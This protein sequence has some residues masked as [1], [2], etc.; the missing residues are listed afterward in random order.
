MKLTVRSSSWNVPNRR[1]KTGSRTFPGVPA[2]GRLRTNFELQTYL[3]SWQKTNA[4][5]AYGPLFQSA[6]GGAPAQFCGGTVASATDGGNMGFSAPHGL[7]PGRRS[8]P[9]TRSALWRRSWTQHR[10]AERAIYDVPRGRRGDEAAVTYSPATSLPTVSI[11]DYWTPGDGGAE[12]ALRRRG[13]SNGDFGQRRLSRVPIQRAGAGC[14]RQQQFLGRRLRRCRASRRNRRSGLSTT[15]SFREIW[16]K[17]GSGP[18][19]SQFFTVT[20]ASIGLKNNLE[21]RSREFG[22]SLPLAIAPGR[23]SVTAAF[24]LYSQET[25]RRAL[26]QAARQESPISVMFQLGN[27]SGQMMAVYLQSVIPDRAGIQRRS[28][29]SAMAIPAFARA[30][31]SGQRNPGGVRITMTYESVEKWSRR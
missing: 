2:G 18:R 26:Y 22:S 17:L 6:L 8:R 21:T 13:G 24:E 4:G 31:H 12:S 14:D 1:D 28:E 27:T 9:R 30:R 3:T 16:D 29:P 11:F 7:V 5:P 23:R 10:G 15:R 25:R 19:P 20:G